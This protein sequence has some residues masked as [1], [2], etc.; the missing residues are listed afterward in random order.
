MT[1]ETDSQG[2]ISLPKEL[3]KKYGERFHV[4]EYDEKIQLIPIADNPL[5]AAREAAGELRD[6]SHDEIEDAI[7][8]WSE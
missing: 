1:I 7:T 4:V 2:G 8:D 6:A 3:R 5:A